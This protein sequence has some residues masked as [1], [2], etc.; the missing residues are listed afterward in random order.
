MR[1][2]WRPN[3]SSL[4]AR[5]P[6]ATS[7]ERFDLVGDAFGTVA[8]RER[9]ERQQAR[10]SDDDFVRSV[11]I[12]IPMVD[13]HVGY[14]VDLTRGI[15]LLPSNVQIG[16]PIGV[17]HCPLPRRSWETR[18]PSDLVEIS[19]GQRLDTAAGVEHGLNDQGTPAAR[20]SAGERLADVAWHHKSLLDRG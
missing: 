5:T 1:S 14:A 6:A 10:P 2:T 9:G 13:E 4:V 11:K 20:T 15:E 8:D 3:A 12:G 18:P 16:A 17:L 7:Q 19:F